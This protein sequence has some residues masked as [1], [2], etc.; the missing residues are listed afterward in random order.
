MRSGNSTSR[1]HIPTLIGVQRQDGAPLPADV[2]DDV[3][4]W[5]EHGQ[6]CAYGYRAEGHDWMHVPE[7]ATFRLGPEITAFADPAASSASIGAAFER[8]VLPMAIQALGG[9]ALHA[10]GVLGPS[11]VVAFSGESGAGKSTAAHALALRGSPIWADDAVAFELVDSVWST[12]RLPFEL[13][14]LPDAASRLALAGSAPAAAARTAT[15]S[16]IV[17]LRRDSV[18]PVSV[19][20]LDGGEAFASL[21]EQAYCF[22]PDAPSPSP[23]LVD[24]YLTLAAHV[25]VLEVRYA[26]AWP[27]FELVVDRLEEIVGGRVSG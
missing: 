6:V 11:G 14:L 17:V 12:T 3:Q 21:L 1:V 7:I 26:P 19:R 20:R 24:A 10:S 23:A 18:E 13:K 4:V 8:S 25:T 9:N 5:R 16:D 2:S 22:R 27:T 15:L